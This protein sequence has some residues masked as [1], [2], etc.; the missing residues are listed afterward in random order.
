MKHTPGPWNQMVKMNGFT[1]VG[2]NTLIARVFSTAFQDLENERA[3]AHLIAAAPDLLE[4]VKDALAFLDRPDITTY[5]W[6]K[7]APK[8]VAMFRR[9]IAKAEG[10]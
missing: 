8:H 2:A 7:L 3:N 10:L 4:A 5:E 1:A 6:Y 9:A